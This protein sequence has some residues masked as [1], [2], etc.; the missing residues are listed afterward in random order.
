[1][2]HFDGNFNVGSMRLN[3]GSYMHVGDKRDVHT[4]QFYGSTSGLS[5]NS[6]CKK[7]KRIFTEI[8]DTLNVNGIPWNAEN[9]SRT[10]TA[11]KGDRISTLRIYG[12]RFVL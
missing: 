2:S 12:D 10:Y 4:N 11:V 1:M 6:I 3:T 8:S 7:L 5:C 9:L